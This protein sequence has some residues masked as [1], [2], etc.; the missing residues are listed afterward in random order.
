MRIRFGKGV[1]F[2]EPT[3]LNLLFHIFTELICGLRHASERG[4][5][6]ATV[7]DGAN[8]GDSGLDATVIN[9]RGGS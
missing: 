2:Y 8:P 5:T 1:L 4:F 9:D 6:G 7:N 3:Q